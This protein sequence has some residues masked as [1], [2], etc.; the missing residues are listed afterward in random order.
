MA[1]HDLPFHPFDTGG[2]AWPALSVDALHVW[3]LP[4]RHGQRSLDALRSNI[5]RYL[6]I[7][8]DAVDLQRSDT[9]QP[10]LVGPASD[11]QFSASHSGDALLLGFVRGSPIGVDIE[12]LKPRPN[13]LQL[14]RRFFAQHEA[15]ALAT[16]PEAEREDAFY[17]L[18]T[19]K[20]ATLK[21]LGRGL[22]H[23][24]DRV[25][26]DFGSDG[27]IGIGPVAAVGIGP[28]QVDVMALPAADAWNLR[29]CVP[30]PGYRACIAWPGANRLIRAWRIG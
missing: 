9:G 10:E 6:D 12:H 13:A 22:A 21:A 11:L 7:D 27:D 4:H 29:E 24:L 17:R 1:T 14:A 15:D 26:F 30:L 20:E 18:W 25:A 8:P 5:A 28:D 2:G 19:A 16:M 23:G 3:L